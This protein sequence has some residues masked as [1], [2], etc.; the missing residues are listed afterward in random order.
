MAYSIGFCAFLGASPTG[1]SFVAPGSTSSKFNRHELGEADDDFQS[2][3]GSATNNTEPTR[4][5]LGKGQGSHCRA[6]RVRLQDVGTHVS[7][8]EHAA[9]TATGKARV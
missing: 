5:Q 4:W 2:G 3:T 6:D 7:G 1:A 8:G 9:G